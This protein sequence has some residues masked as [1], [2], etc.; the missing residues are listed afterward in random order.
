MDVQGKYIY[1]NPVVG[2]LLGYQTDEVIGK[3][4]YEF[5]SDQHKT[6]IKIECFKLWSTWKP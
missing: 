2:I 5:F 6:A 4:F 3:Y 1:S